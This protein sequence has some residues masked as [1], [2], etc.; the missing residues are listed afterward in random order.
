VGRPLCSK[1]FFTILGLP[2][3]FSFL[4]TPFA[5][6][7]FFFFPGSLLTNHFIPS[8]SPPVFLRMRHYSLCVL[9]PPLTPFSSTDPGRPGRS[10]LQRPLFLT[11]S[12]LFQDL[13]F[14]SVG[15][16]PFPIAFKLYFMLG[17]PWFLRFTPLLAFPYCLF[18]NKPRC[19]ILFPELFWWSF[20]EDPPL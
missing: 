4:K 6:L 14:V 12:A 15:E 2:L 16:K 7:F 8:F 11:A 3:H 5:V 18:P 9:H 1:F 19:F 10:P 20:K 13:T 17:D